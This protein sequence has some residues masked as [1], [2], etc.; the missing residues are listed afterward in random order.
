ME[1]ITGKAHWVTKKHQSGSIRLYAWEKFLPSR[2]GRFAGTVLLVHGSSMAST[3]TFDLQVSG[4]GEAYSM[5]DYFARLGYDV[6]CFDCEGYGRSDKT[7]DSKFFI[8]DGADD[9]EAVGDEICRLRGVGKLLVYGISSGA[10]RAAM[11]AERR[12]ERVERLVLDAF[13]WTGQGSPTLEQRRKGLPAML[14][15]NRRPVDAAFIR[16]I[17]TRDHPGTAADEVV[18][19]F[20]EAVVA[21]DDS[22]PNGTY[23][24]MCQNLP[25]VDPGRIQAPVLITRGQY[26]G[27]A[28]LDD[29]LSFFKLL[30]NQDKHFA[31]MAGSA[32]SSVHERNHCTLLHIIASFW[33]QPEPV[34]LG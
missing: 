26:D 29:L 20:A 1:E 21:L 30:Q 34:Y 4:Q 13:V 16:S 2:E 24:D 28:G 11:F 12:P 9:T 25:L 33:S 18:A 8:V 32:H 15:T 19:A 6:W 5:M 31:V 22:V 27:I 17:F 23:I 7:R 3:P 10:L 14:A